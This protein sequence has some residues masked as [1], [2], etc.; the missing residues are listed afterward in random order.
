MDDAIGLVL[1]GDDPEGVF[2]LPAGIVVGKRCLAI[3]KGTPW[4]SVERTIHL[5]CDLAN[6][7]HSDLPWQLGDLLNA[8]EETYGEDLVNQ[9]IRLT[10]WT[11]ETLGNYRWAARKVPPENRHLGKDTLPVRYGMN[12]APLPPEEQ[13]RVL[14]IAA[15]ESLSANECHR[16]ALGDPD[17][18][19]KAVPE[20]GATHK[21]RCMAAFPRVY[22]HNEARLRA[23]TL[24]DSCR[25]LWE[26]AV[27]MALDKTGRKK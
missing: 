26:L 15:K 9:A 27:D 17:Y 4:A 6:Y 14:Q 24:Q 23:E 8:A 11:F 25:L 2:A 13:K 1:R 16:L 22:A 19:R 3:R 18:K 20:R 12:V 10:G 21:E 5:M 7:S